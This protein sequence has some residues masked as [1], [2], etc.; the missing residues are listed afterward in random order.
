MGDK[1]AVTSLH[2]DHYENI[3]CV[4]RGEKTFTLLPPTDQPYIPYKE[5]PVGQYIRQTDG[6]WSINQDGS[7]GSVPWIPV[8]SLS[9]SESPFLV[10]PYVRV[11]Y[12]IRLILHALIWSH[13]LS[14]RMHISTK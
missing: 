9:S 3:Y 8:S 2:K 11:L 1:R 14:S 13:T 4:V 10:R 6:G 7:L 5:V 12:Y